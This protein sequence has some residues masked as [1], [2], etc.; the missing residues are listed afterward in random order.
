MRKNK[1]ITTISFFFYSN[2]IKYVRLGDLDIKSNT[3]NASPQQFTVKKTFI[4]PSYKSPNRYHDIALI[5]LDKK[6]KF[7]KYVIP[8]C[9]GLS[10]DLNGTNP[11]VAG[12][13]LTRRGGDP[14]NILQTAPMAYVSANVCRKTYP[15]S[16]ALTRGIDDD[17]M[18][19]AGGGTNKTDTCQVRLP[20]D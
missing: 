9:V 2:T 18:I 13:G 19:C 11:T 14:A 3:D 15:K 20:Q 6:V 8:A 7:T 12:W 1:T 4:H 10:T 5:Q 17:L 16:F